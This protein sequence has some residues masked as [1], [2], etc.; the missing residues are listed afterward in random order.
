MH[1]FV[2]LSEICTSY[3][4]V[5]ILSEILSVVAG[6]QSKR[7][8]V[9]YFLFA[10]FGKRTHR[11]ESTKM[12]EN[13]KMIV[14]SELFRFQAVEKEHWRI[15]QL[16][17]AEAAREE[18]EHTKAMEPKQQ[19][20]E[21]KERARNHHLDFLEKQNQNLPTPLIP[22][23]PKILKWEQL[24]PAYNE[25]GDIAEYLTTFERLHVVH[26]IPDDQKM[27]T[28]VADLTGAANR[29]FR[30][31]VLQVKEELIQHLWVTSTR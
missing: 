24:C 12:S 28:I 17:P 2:V 31:G 3:T 1:N 15:L 26:K 13:S 30:K 11:Q 25:A 23:S 7:L 29:E 18:D 16:N 9:C 6:D 10:Y 20:T 8:S 5:E 4:G 27:P 21:E 22:S 14:K 19:E